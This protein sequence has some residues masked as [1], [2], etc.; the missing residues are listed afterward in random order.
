MNKI[1]LI[2]K[3]EYLNRVKKK[4]FLIM[5]IFGPVIFGAFIIGAVALAASDTTFNKIL[6]ADEPGYLIED[7]VIRY[8]GQPVER[9]HFRNTDNISFDFRKGIVDPAYELE[10]GGYTAVIQLFEVSYTDGHVELHA[11]KTP[12]MVVQNNIKNDIEE[13]IES[14]NARTNNIDPGL[15]KSIRK[16]VNF[17]LIKPSAG[18]K[19]THT[20]EKAMIG[21]GLALLIYIFIFFY[22][23]QV[24]RGVMEEKTN[25]VVEVIISSVK[26]FQ[27][28]MGKVVGIGL[29]G[30][31]QFIIWV[32][33][34]SAISAFGLASY[35]Q[36]LVEM[37]MANMG[38]NANE[39]IIQG[40]N[41]ASNTAS[42]E[43]QNEIL[44]IIN[45]VPWIDVL[46]SFIFYFIGGY[47]VYASLFA[48]IGAA[49]D[50]ET[51]TQQ[52]MMPV[53]IPLIFAYI[54]SVMMMNNPEGTIGTIFSIVP[55]TSPVVMMVKTAIGVPIWLKLISMAVLILS[56]IFFIWLAGRIYR[57]GILMYGKKP[58]Y[59]E[60]WKWIRYQG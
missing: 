47:L 12:S 10:H 49:V 36:Q 33:L 41:L 37:Q 6:I 46:L 28:M 50:Q 15:Y 57:V 21:F 8:Q 26:P 11:E 35:Q 9:A 17:S 23:L 3:R 27:L 59:K 39:G 55:L 22:G 5:T 18:N 13:V 58:T 29:V 30:L 20:S 25:R 24:M 16:S 7:E 1:W 52:F 38:I 19:K 53:T 45:E 48:A 51:D 54:V 4:S 60:L 14:H 43:S 56:F 42:I 44:E 31:T 34:T 32:V 2:I 40:Q